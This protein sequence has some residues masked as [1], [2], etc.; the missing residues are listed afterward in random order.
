M[1]GT[2]QVVLV[3]KNKNMAENDIS[4][5]YLDDENDYPVVFIKDKIDQKVH[6]YIFKHVFYPEMIR[7]SGNKPILFT[8]DGE[9][10]QMNAIKASFNLD[11]VMNSED[12]DSDLEGLD[13]VIMIER[14][15]YVPNMIVVKLPANTS[16]IIQPNDVGKHFTLVKQHFHKLM[17]KEKNSKYST[18]NENDYDFKDKKDKIIAKLNNLNQNNLL[19]PKIHPFRAANSYEKVA[20]LLLKFQSVLKKV[21]LSYKGDEFRNAFST[22]C[23]KSIYNNDHDIEILP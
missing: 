7:K 22:T 19:P 6:E 3:Y 1:D 16:S 10:S 11:T 5:F 9:N 12:D 4:L 17:S 2:F 20:D 13:E 23:F 15:E 18:L 8:I 14:R 21:Y